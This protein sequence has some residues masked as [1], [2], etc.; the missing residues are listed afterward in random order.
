MPTS[1]IAYSKIGTLLKDWQSID[2]KEW[3]DQ[4]TTMQTYRNK[5]TGMQLVVYI[6]SCEVCRTPLWLN[7]KKLDSGLLHSEHHL[8]D[9]CECD[10]TTNTTRDLWSPQNLS[11]YVMHHEKPCKSLVAQVETGTD[12]DCE[13]CRNLHSIICMVWVP[14]N[15]SRPEY[16]FNYLSQPLYLWTV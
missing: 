8:T 3:W 16:S 5:H 6:I 11:T 12:I 7:F 1:D 14:G 13:S 9:Q 4:F 2:I 10:E 15:D